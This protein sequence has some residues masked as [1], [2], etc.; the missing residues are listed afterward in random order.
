MEDTKMETKKP[1]FGDG[2]LKTSAREL[3]V[4]VDDNGDSWICDKE[5]AQNIDRNVPFEKQN[6]ERCQVMPFDH[7]G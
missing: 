1:I 7:G 4:F 2:V 5:E 6:L 3:V